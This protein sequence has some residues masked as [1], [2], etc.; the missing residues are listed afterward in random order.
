M[1]EI[2]TDEY[3]KWEYQQDNGSISRRILEPT[4]KYIDEYGEVQI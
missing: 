1:L 3:G 4:Q 2:K